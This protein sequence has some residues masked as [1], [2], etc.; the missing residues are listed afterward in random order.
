MSAADRRSRLRPLLHGFFGGFDSF[1]RPLG[2]LTIVSFEEKCSSTR[3]GEREAGEDHRST[4]FAPFPPVSFHG[5]NPG[6]RFEKVALSS[7][8]WALVKMLLL[9]PPGDHSFGHSWSKQS[10]H[11]GGA[12]DASDR[13]LRFWMNGA[14]Q[15]G[16][17]DPIR[18]F[19]R[20]DRSRG[21]V[22][23]VSR[24][25]EQRRVDGAG[26]DRADVD[27]PRVQKLQAKAFRP[28]ANGK[29]A[30]GVGA[31]VRH[32]NLSQSGRM[33]DQD[34][35]ALP[36]KIGKNR[37]GAVDVA[38]EIRFDDSPVGI[39]W[40]LFEPA[41]EG[42]AGIVD[43]NI[44]A[45]KGL[46]RLLGQPDDGPFIG[47]I[48]WDRQSPDTA[49]LALGRNLP[50]GPLL[51]CREDNMAAPASDFPSQSASNAAGG[52]G[53]NKNVVPYFLHVNI[54]CSMVEGRRRTRRPEPKTIGELVRLSIRDGPDSNTGKSEAWP[55]SKRVRRTMT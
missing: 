35:P 7:G 37:S 49:L 52:S 42:G 47:D 36:A 8:R 39:G 55:L 11:E 5:V 2:E 14:S 28:A 46:K 12:P 23:I 20:G 50:Q 34:S 51:S 38:K 16:F 31:C 27:V 26:N 24:V 17:D 21:A 13:D 18:R 19:D 45:A 40:R 30:R 33:I 48:R 25:L 9:H 15:D 10:G 53:N 43:P 41:K 54:L 44:D 1:R 29:I 3:G 22:G 6:H 32:A 4:L